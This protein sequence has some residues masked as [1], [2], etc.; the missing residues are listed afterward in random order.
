[1]KV[2]VPSAAE[3]ENASLRESALQGDLLRRFAA[4][5]EAVVRPKSLWRSDASQ[6]L[7]GKAFSRTSV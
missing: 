2:A 4:G 7:P 6:R 3:K 5:N 1:M